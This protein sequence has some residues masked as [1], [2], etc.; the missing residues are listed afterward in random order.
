[1]AALIRQSFINQGIPGIQISVT[2]DLSDCSA[3]VIVNTDA[4]PLPNSASGVDFESAIT[5]EALRNL[6]LPPGLAIVWMNQTH[7]PNQGPVAAVVVKS[8]WPAHMAAVYA[9]VGLL[10]LLL[11]GG[12]VRALL[13]SLRRTARLREELLAQAASHLMPPPLP[14][15]QW[16]VFLSYRVASDEELVDVLYNK[17]RLEGLRVWRDVDCLDV[18]GKWEEGFADGL[19]GSAIFVPVISKAALAPFAAL[20]ANS[21]CDNLLLEF[22]LARILKMRGHLCHIAPLLIGDAFSDLG[23]GLG[24][25]YANFYHGGGAPTCRETIDGSVELKATNHLQR[26]KHEPPGAPE[27]TQQTLDEILAHTCTAVQG[28][29]RGALDAAVAHIAA[30]AMLDASDRSGTLPPP[31]PPFTHHIFLSYRASTDASLVTALREKLQAHGLLVCYSDESHAGGVF[32]CALF[33][34]VLTKAALEPFASLNFHSECDGMLIE[35]RL[36]LILKERNE[37]SCILPL[38][39]GSPTEDLGHGLGAGFAD[40]FKGGS[41]PRCPTGPVASVEVATA[42]LLTRTGRPR[43]DGEP[44][45]PQRILASILEHQGVLLR[46]VQSDAVATAISRL[47]AKAV[48]IAAE[49]QH[50]RAHESDRLSKT[51]ELTDDS[52]TGRGHSRKQKLQS[53]NRVASKRPSERRVSNEI[54]FES[55]LST[56]SGPSS[57]ELP[58]LPLV[59]RRD[60]R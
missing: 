38:L 7:A 51:L 27:S 20:D 60:G 40:F 48:K 5:Y 44:H 25:G 46:G 23:H 28:M 52:E 3:Q 57:R 18:G 56:Q 53:G 13:R 54:V 36:A 9:C 26:A 6:T 50:A 12:V 43:L 16:H 24:A 58:T 49:E 32:A 11:G 45:G 8:K 2:L 4:E 59:S 1:M 10:I 39:V 17:L 22:R 33:V 14:P 29:K 41:V 15:H 47:V 19:F 35:Q 30:L 21:P 37:I 31:P 55:M 34:P 42:A